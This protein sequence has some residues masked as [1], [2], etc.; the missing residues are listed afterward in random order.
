MNVPA[1]GMICLGFVLGGLAGA[2]FAVIIP[3]LYLK[4][5]FGLAMLGVGTKMLFF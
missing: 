5:V 4:R 1:A 2:K 3:A